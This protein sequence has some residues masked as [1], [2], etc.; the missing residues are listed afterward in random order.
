GLVTDGIL[1]MKKADLPVYVV[2]ADY[3]KRSYLKSVHSLIS[4]NKFEHLSVV[5]NG[6]KTGK[7]SYGYGYGYGYYED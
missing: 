4:N 5:L 7:G 2:R 6:V 1:V 3:S